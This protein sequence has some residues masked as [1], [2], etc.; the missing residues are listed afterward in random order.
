M[1]VTGVR[2]EYLDSL[3]V[4]YRKVL[5]AAGVARRMGVARMLFSRPQIGRAHALLY[6]NQKTRKV[7]D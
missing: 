4:P 6:E 2:R 1:P 7:K 5:E 3:G